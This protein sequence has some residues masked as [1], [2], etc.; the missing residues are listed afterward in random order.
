MTE[1]AP[2]PDS[3]LAP[4]PLGE[5]DT[6]PQLPYLLRIVFWIKT[7][8]FPNLNFTLFRSEQIYC[9]ENNG[10][11]LA[12]LVDYAFRVMARNQQVNDPSFL[13]G[14]YSIERWN[15]ERGWDTVYV[16]RPYTAPPPPYTEQ[17]PPDTQPELKYL[18]RGEYDAELGWCYWHN[19]VGDSGF[20]GWGDKETAT[21]FTKDEVE[22]LNLPMGGEWVREDVA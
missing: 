13:I 4:Q 10:V 20:A 17:P 8:I 11:T 5:F 18:I 15:K 3:T 2:I 14:Q 7:P 22:T 1:P 16:A 19:D 9:C 6:N 12:K 21:K